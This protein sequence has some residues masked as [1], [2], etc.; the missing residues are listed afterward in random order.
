MIS[1]FKS[2]VQDFAA[3]LSS[4][5]RTPGFGLRVASVGFLAA[6]L[7]LSKGVRTMIEALVLGV[8][9]VVFIGYPCFAGAA[10]VTSGRGDLD[11]P[12][13]ST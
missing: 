2:E 11:P 1:I 4:M 8:A 13:D 5:R 6:S 10:G 7:A 3:F 12:H 9:V